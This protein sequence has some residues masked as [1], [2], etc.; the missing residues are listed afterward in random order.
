MLYVEKQ[1]KN[2]VRLSTWIVRN[3]GKRRTNLPD[4]FE[5]REQTGTP[6]RAK[7]GHELPKPAEISGVRPLGPHLSICLLVVNSPDGKNLYEPT[8]DISVIIEL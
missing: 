6:R 5:Y 8:T 3:L 4:I 1:V 7:I 2:L